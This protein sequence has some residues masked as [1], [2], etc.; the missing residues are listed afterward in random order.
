MSGMMRVTQSIRK[1]IFAYIKLVYM[2][3]YAIK[4]VKQWAQTGK[5]N[6]CNS[7]TDKELLFQYERNSYKNKSQSNKK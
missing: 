7:L 4:K 6:I 1:Y 3:K 2:T 5:K